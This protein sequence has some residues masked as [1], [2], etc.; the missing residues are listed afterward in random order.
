MLARTDEK[1]AEVRMLGVKPMQVQTVRELS[2]YLSFLDADT[3]VQLD[4]SFP[5][6]IKR[7]G[8]LSI[9]RW[10]DDEVVQGHFCTAANCS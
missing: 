9:E 2:M 7:P 3:K 6:F 4:G 5:T 1:I 10:S 8:A